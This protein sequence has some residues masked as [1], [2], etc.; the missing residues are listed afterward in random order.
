MYFH[1]GLENLVYLFSC[2]FC[3][4]WTWTCFLK[5][6]ACLECHL[7][8]GGYNSWKPSQCFP[9]GFIYILRAACS[10]TSLSVFLSFFLVCLTMSLPPFSNQLKQT[11]ESTSCPSGGCA[12]PFL[13]VLSLSW[14][15]TLCSLPVSKA[16]ETTLE[17]GK[18]GEASRNMGWGWGVKK[19]QRWREQWR[20]VISFP[21]EQ[22]HFKTKDVCDETLRHSAQASGD[23]ILL[24]WHLYEATVINSFSE[25]SET[26]TFVE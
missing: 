6:L 15:D 2:L 8:N 22:N 16:W 26:K 17:G 7:I 21:A 11:V 18:G 19:R 1:S 20:A 9:V 10:F 12:R 5:T 4:V 13:C 3:F 25:M 24:P 14:A 23:N